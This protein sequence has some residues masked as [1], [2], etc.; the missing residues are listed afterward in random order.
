MAEDEVLGRVVRA[1]CFEG[2]DN[3]LVI[4]VEDEVAVLET[5]VNDCAEAEI[6]SDHLC[7]ANV[8]IFVVPAIPKFPG[9]PVVVDNKADA[10]GCG[11]VN[12][13]QIQKGIRRG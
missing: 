9:K 6:D 7:P 2:F 8:T 4:R 5:G 13:D 12:E 11:G 3:T 1:A 10:K